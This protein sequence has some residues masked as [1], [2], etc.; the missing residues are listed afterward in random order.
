VQLKK[1]PPRIPL[2][3]ATLT[4]A[5][6]LRGSQPATAAAKIANAAVERSMRIAVAVLSLPK[7]RSKTN[8]TATEPKHPE[9]VMKHP[10][11]AA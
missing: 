8:P 11:H 1:N 9:T 3:Y 10:S 7:N 5:A 2:A 6:W 4:V